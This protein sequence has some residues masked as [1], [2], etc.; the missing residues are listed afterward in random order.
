MKKIFIIAAVVIVAGLIG[1]SCNT[2]KS[3][4]AYGGHSA[5]ECAP[6]TDEV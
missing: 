3:C 6:I 2:H 5:V 1:S 4:P